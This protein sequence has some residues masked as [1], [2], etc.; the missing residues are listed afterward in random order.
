VTDRPP[1]QRAPQ[2][3]AKVRAGYDAVAGA[4]TERVH[5]ELFGKPIDRGLLMAFADQV[6]ADFGAGSAVCDMGCGPGHIG[7]FLAA[8]GLTVTGI[9]LSPSMIERARSLHPDVTFEVGTMTQLAVRDRSFRGVS[10]FYSIIHL[11]GDAEVAAALA[12]FHRVLDDRGVLLVAV[13]LAD[14]ADTLVHADDMLGVPVDMDFRFFELDRLAGD[15]EAAGFVVEARLVR[16]PYPDVE[17]QT[18]RGY[19]LARR[20][21]ETRAGQKAG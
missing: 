9:D 11:A 14:G 8:T 10:A 15:V 1:G 7:A 5:D 20:V 16:A 12:E 2:D 19:L 3:E 17:V 4:Y 13:H 21:E 18:T 6:A